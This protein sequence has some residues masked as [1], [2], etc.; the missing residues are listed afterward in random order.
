MNQRVLG[1]TSLQ[2]S[3][4]GFGCGKLAAALR[5]ADTHEAA[6]TLLDAY[7]RGIT[8]YDTAASYGQGRSER[9]LGEA[10]HSKRQSIIIATKAGY[11][12]SAAA[13]LA[14]KIKPL[15]SPLMRRVSWLRRSAQRAAGTQRQQSF[16]PEYL[17]AAIEGSLRRLQTDY[18]DIFLLHSP[19]RDVLQA[20]GWVDVLER[21]KQ[22][23]KIRC[24]GVSCRSAE[25]AIFCSEIPGISCVQIPVNLSE[26]DAI[27][28]VLEYLKAAGIG[29]L[30]RQPLAS[31]LLAKP[32]AE[33][34]CGD[35]PWDRAEFE[36][37]AA[38]IRAL[39]DLSGCADARVHAAL[40]YVLQLP[41][42]VSVILGMSSREHLR[43][44]LAAVNEQYQ[45]GITVQNI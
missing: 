43:Q 28:S 32:I 38:K 24:Y 34:R 45:T 41:G 19:E 40:T 31:G 13:T 35:F 36:R 27:H 5:R 1:C 26:S 17:R 3:E 9:M 25:D 12:L 11:H 37:R 22:Q 18:I 16:S 15:V 14:A 44:N 4:I 29:V 7:E 39:P 2:V 42:I 33:L 21:V 30:A 23:G 10:F 8:F 20:A 6:R